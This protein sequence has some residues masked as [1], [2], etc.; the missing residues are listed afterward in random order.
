[1]SKTPRMMVKGELEAVAQ[2]RRPRPAVTAL[3]P[4]TKYSVHLRVQFTVK[5][6]AE[7]ESA[8]RTHW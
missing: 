4:G 1:M 8:F 6:F 7:A 3:S 2:L 5:L